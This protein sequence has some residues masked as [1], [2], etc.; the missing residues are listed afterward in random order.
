MVENNHGPA[1][2]RAYEGGRAPRLPGLGARPAPKYFRIEKSNS[3][4]IS[5]WGPV[6][7]DGGPYISKARV[8]HSLEH[9]FHVCVCPLF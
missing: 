2:P 4:N 6:Y 9:Y 5:K 1:R 3:F 8:P 7:Y